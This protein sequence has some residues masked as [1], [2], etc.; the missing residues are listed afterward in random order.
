VVSPAIDGA[1]VALSHPARRELLRLCTESERTV[2]ELSEL[3]RL[4]QPA[5]SQHLRTL[6]DAGLVVVRA[7]GNRRLYQVDF[8]RL[9]HVRSALDD[10]W[11]SR[12]PALK[13]AAEARARQT[14]G[15][16]RS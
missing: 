5:T 11:G 16:D 14:A 9:A 7:D 15:T 3:V 6:R 12:L 4:R 13:R 10:L 2:A 8:A 1:L